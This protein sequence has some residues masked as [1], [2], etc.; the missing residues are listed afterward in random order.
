MRKT[1]KVALLTAMALALSFSSLLPTTILASAG[2][3][4]SNVASEASIVDGRINTGDFMVS[5]GV[6]G[7]GNAIVFD[8]D[9]AESAKVIGKTKINNS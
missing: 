4:R 3:S 5:G 8:K 6:H 9:C 2:S 1:K 7:E